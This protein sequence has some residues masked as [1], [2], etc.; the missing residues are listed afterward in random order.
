MKITTERTPLVESRRELILSGS[1]RQRRLE[2][3]ALNSHVFV[4]AYTDGGLVVSVDGPLAR[5][6]LAKLDGH[7]LLSVRGASFMLARDEYE[8]LGEILPEASS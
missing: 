1:K 4:F 8:R 2:I 6:R 3:R 7:Y 5:C